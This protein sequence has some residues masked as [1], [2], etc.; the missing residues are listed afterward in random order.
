MCGSVGNSLIMRHTHK[1]YDADSSL[2][3]TTIIGLKLLFRSDLI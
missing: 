1:Q 2:V 3:R